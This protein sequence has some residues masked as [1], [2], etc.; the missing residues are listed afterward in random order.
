[1]NDEKIFSRYLDLSLEYKDL[2]EIYKYLY[3]EL[4]ICEKK[5]RY[6]KKIYDRNNKK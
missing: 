4:M 5:L 2:K 6:Y 3:S 1:M